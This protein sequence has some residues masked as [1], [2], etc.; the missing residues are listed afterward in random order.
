MRH[1]IQ[2][3]GKGGQG[4][5]LA[6]SILSRACGIYDGKNLVETHL[7]GAAARGGLSESE[8]VI[9]GEEI[10]YVKV[11]N[12]DFLVALSQDAYDEYG[13][14]V[15][16]DGMIIADEFYV[17][18]YNAE[19]KRLAMFPLTRTA[20]DVVGALI[21]VNVVTLGVLSALDP[22]L[23]P[24]SVRSA[25]KDLVAGKYLDKNLKA[26]DKGLELGESK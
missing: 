11:Q 16:D 19:D 1:E 8:L 10:Y 15:K 24:E 23:S 3:V 18:N 14:A 20:L 22:E 21:A 26:F 6:S 13:A 17:K 2:L 12:P 9:S 4:V 25:I 5:R 7:Y